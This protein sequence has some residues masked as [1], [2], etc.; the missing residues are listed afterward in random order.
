MP[1]DRRTGYDLEPK[2]PGIIEKD[3]FHI[4]PDFRTENR[5]VVGNPPF[6][7][8]SKVAIPFFN[9]AA[10][11]ADTVAFIVPGS[12]KRFTKQSRLDN[13]MSLFYY[14][15]LSSDSFYRP[16]G[17]DYT[18]Q[19]IFQIWHK[20]HPLCKRAAKPETTHP[21]FKISR[22]SLREKSLSVW[23]T[24]DML[25][26]RVR[27]SLPYPRLTTPDMPQ[28]KEYH[29]FTVCSGEVLER[30]KTFDFE[31]IA[32]RYASRESYEFLGSDVIRAY[33]EK[34]G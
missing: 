24:Y 30:L 1:A 26:P 7:Y 20:Y 25:I 31:S 27:R 33:K 22:L 10:A 13:R 6:G 11:M 3:W 5:V 32:E 16:N 18:S 29:A 15:K 14:E 34:Y 21:D 8:H 28:N 12:W 17:E 2:Y 4:V 19:C 23:D 9:H